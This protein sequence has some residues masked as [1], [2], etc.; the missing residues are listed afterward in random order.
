MPGELR[1][2]GKTRIPDAN[3]H[4]LTI[5][6]LVAPGAGSL[7]SGLTE[8]FSAVGV[9]AHGDLVLTGSSLRFEGDSVN[10][11]FI[12]RTG[13]FTI[14]LRSITGIDQGGSFLGSRIV[15]LRT[16]DGEVQI[17]PVWAPGGVD[18]DGFL[19]AL[20][21]GVVNAGGRV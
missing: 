20:R 3:L 10:Q 12:G 2:K 16:T 11:W 4:F 15:T 9:W 14:D 18:T 8:L 17:N 1:K 7:T 6:G 5:I 21:Q 19:A 13:S